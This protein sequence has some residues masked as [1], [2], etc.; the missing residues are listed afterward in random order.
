MLGK[1]TAEFID[2]EAVVE[3]EAQTVTIEEE[4]NDQENQ[5]SDVDTFIDD[6][7]KEDDDVD[8]YRQLENIS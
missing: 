4:E 2:F 1:K 6:A 7:E 3:S 5:V 8:F